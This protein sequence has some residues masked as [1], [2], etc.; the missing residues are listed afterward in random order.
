MDLYHSL[1]VTAV[2][3]QNSEDQYLDDLTSSCRSSFSTAGPLTPQSSRRPSVQSPDLIWPGS[4]TSSSF[5][6]K[7]WEQAMGMS[8]DLLGQ[9]IPQ[10]CVSSH[11]IPTPPTI[12]QYSNHLD[13]HSDPHMQH[14]LGGRPRFD[15]MGQLTA[16]WSQAGL[17]S[18][19]EAFS[20]NDP[21]NFIAVSRDMSL[22][23]GAPFTGVE[24]GSTYDFF[25]Q[26]SQQHPPLMYTINP[27]QTSFRP[28]S[29]ALTPQYFSTPPLLPKSEYLET[30]PEMSSHS[31]TPESV[32][33][34]RNYLA[35]SFFKQNLIS[36]T[37][38]S[39]SHRMSHMNGSRGKILGRS[40]LSKR[41][42]VSKARGRTNNSDRVAKGYSFEFDTVDKSMEICNWKISDTQMCGKKFK[43]NEHLKRHQR[44]HES[45]IQ[46]SCQ[47][48][49]CSKKFLDRNDNMNQHIWK[50]HFLDSGHGRNIRIQSRAE[51]ET[52]GWGHLWDRKLAEE[53]TGGIIVEPV[54]ST[55]VRRSKKKRT[56][57]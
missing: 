3:Y 35:E 1:S 56:K 30:I 16:S 47:M 12:A 27:T 5:T 25:P 53:R 42:V 48:Q 50:T 34:E 51:A 29:P 4:A 33:P 22:P 18:S 43:R 54:G 6:G 8:E 40:K 41:D 11:Q 24:L 32:K 26:D 20:H 28:V 23:I 21:S 10:Y 55:D 45:K 46:Y 31:V 7:P 9:H 17:L 19:Q 38:G 36:P 57:I 2:P 15:S 39:P 44:T 52:Y 13:L 14:G 37:R 49:H